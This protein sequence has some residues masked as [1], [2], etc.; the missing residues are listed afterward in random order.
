[1]LAYNG[2]ADPVYRARNIQVHFVDLVDSF[3]SQVVEA[4]K[5]HQKTRDRGSIR[6]AQ[7]PS[8]EAHGNEV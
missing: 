1:M 7:P 8:I 4:P 2:T 6:G 3:F 5:D